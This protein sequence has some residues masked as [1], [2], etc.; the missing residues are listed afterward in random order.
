[1]EKD[2][3][4]SIITFG[5]NDDYNGGFAKRMELNLT[6]LIDNVS[7]FPSS[8][9]EIICV[10]WASPPSDKLSD[11][12]N[13]PSHPNLKFVYVPLEIATKYSPDSEFSIP[14]AMNCGVRNSKGKY[15]LIC[16]GD[17]Y[18]PYDTLLKAYNLIESNKEEDLWYWSS[19]YHLPPE[20][21]LK[22]SNIEELDKA[23]ESWENN[24]KPTTKNTKLATKKTWTFHKIS[25]NL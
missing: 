20:I 7:N 16:D 5:K 23:I 25:I 12:M 15:L 8:S 10:D 17:I 18:T 19:R 9:I 3:L 6:K 24:N 22:V 2:I 4:L 1:M 14:H 13:L 21:H 11:V